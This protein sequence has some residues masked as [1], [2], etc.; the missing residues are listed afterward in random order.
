MNNLYLVNLILFLQEIPIPINQISFRNFY[1]M[2]NS[3]LFVAKN[4]RFANKEIILPEDLE[5]E[6]LICYQRH[7]PIWAEIEKQLVGVPRYKE[8]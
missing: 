2:I 5:G 3:L 1:L 8:N 4:H 7:T 6:T